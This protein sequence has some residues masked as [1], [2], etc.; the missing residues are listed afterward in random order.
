MTARSLYERRIQVAISMRSRPIRGYRSATCA[1][2]HPRF[3]TFV[4]LAT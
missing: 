3:V 2:C 4:K 1:G